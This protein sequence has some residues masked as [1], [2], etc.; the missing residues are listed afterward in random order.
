MT[1]SLLARSSV[2]SVPFRG[3]CTRNGNKDGEEEVD[4]YMEL[5]CN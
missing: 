4:A 5:V 2:V 3:D 1:V